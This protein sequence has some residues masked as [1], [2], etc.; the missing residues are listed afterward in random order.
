VLAS[1]DS[2]AAVRRLIRPHGQLGRHAEEFQKP[3]CAGG[4]VDFV[5][6]RP[7]ENIGENMLPILS[8]I[9]D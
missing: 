7:L 1:A 4:I 5:V 9:Y 3:G 6:A 2:G 8:F